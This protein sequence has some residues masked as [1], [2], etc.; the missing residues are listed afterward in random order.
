MDYKL[1]SFDNKSVEV[2]SIKQCMIVTLIQDPVDVLR[3]DTRM[4]VNKK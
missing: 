4:G 1:C 2:I 3:T